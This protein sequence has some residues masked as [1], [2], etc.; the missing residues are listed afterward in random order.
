MSDAMTSERVA[1]GRNGQPL[2]SPASG[3]VNRY[4]YDPLGNLMASDESVENSFRSMGQSGWV[5]D[6]DLGCAPDRCGASAV[7][8][9]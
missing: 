8:R 3:V 9:L 4:R 6:G 1:S 2:S 7:R 5:D